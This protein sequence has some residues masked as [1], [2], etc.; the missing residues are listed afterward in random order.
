MGSACCWALQEGRRN[1]GNSLEGSSSGCETGSVTVARVQTSPLLEECLCSLRRLLRA[2]EYPGPHGCLT[3][4][5]TC[6]ALVTEGTWPHGGD[7]RGGHQTGL[8]SQGMLTSCT[9]SHGFE[10]KHLHL[11]V[12]SKVKGTAGSHKVINSLPPKTACKLNVQNP[13]VHDGLSRHWGP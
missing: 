11:Q 12:I 6:Q 7:G 4:A 13:P 3:G 1:E 9:E 8:L 10:I 2:P 5:G